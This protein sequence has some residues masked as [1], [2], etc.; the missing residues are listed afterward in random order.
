MVSGYE[1]FLAERAQLNC[2]S[3]FEPLWLPGVLFGH[4]QELS[5]WAIRQ[6]RGALFADCGLGKTLMELT[7]AQNVH[8]HSGKPVLLLAPLGVSFQ[9]RDE[10]R[11]FGIEAEISRD[12][13]VAGPVTITNYERLHLFSRDEDAEQPDLFGGAS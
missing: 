4:Q 10:A 9:L 2:A 5:A 11:K 7:W 1:E 8:Q 3:G 13:T 6:G 12:G